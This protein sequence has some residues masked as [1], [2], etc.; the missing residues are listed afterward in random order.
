VK[1]LFLGM[2]IFST[3]AMSAEKIRDPFNDAVIS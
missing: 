1:L 2:L 3:A